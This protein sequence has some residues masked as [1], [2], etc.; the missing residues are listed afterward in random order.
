LL[1][2]S[3]IALS[4][5][6]LIG[7]G[8][9][10]RSF[11]GLLQVNPGFETRNILTARFSLP[12]YSYPDATQQSEFYAQVM[13]QIK[14]L[15]GVTAVGVTDELPPT[16]GTHSST[17]SIEGHAPIEQSDQSLSV[18]NRLVSADYFRVMG[19][20]LVVGRAFSAADDG[21]A[22]PVALINQTFARLFFP[23]EDPIGQHLR[24]ASTNLDSWI[25]VVGVVGDV[26]GF[27]L[28]K[29]PKSE[30]Y[31]PYQQQKFF[32]YNPLPQM[33]VVV[34]TAGDQNGI[35]ATALGLVRELHKDLP[36]PQTRTMETVLAAS[37]AERRSNM[38]LLG[39]F[40]VIA[41]ILTA[42]GVYGVIS[43]SVSQRTQEIGIRIVLGAQSRDVILLVMRNG[44]GLVL[45]GI[46][47]GI[48]GAFALTRWMASLLF[49]V[50][51]TDPLTFVM[52]ALLLAVVALLACWI[53][54][55]RV[56]KV[57]PLVALRYE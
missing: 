27:G 38:L 28:D 34:R 55:R 41:L 4:M 49:V 17:F 6:L 35:A 15:P 12:K 1:T 14:A 33:H 11:V 43:Y 47:I 7:A 21:F 25:T 56:T 46:V 32:P 30:I 45:L 54:A 53:P 57:D 51:A 16:M 39:V 9:L 48:A 22:T 23:N 40:A 26:R 29:Q 18:Q 13:E 5:I 37:I 24:Y 19:I 36:L 8:L 42:V 2:V 3:E 10:I 20:P 50:S 52:I 31:L 44:M